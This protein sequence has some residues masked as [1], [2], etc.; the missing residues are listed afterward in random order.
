MAAAQ[1]P[2]RKL[3]KMAMSNDVSH[4]LVK[5]LWNG[6]SARALIHTTVW[7][8]TLAGRRLLRKV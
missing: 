5:L 2:Q 1:P 7:L 8:P 6:I 3:K 4:P